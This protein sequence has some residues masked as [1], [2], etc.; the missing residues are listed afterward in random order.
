MLVGSVLKEYGYTNIPLS[1]FTISLIEKSFKALAF[2]L[3]PLI[4]TQ[5]EIDFAK[6]IFL[7][8]LEEELAKKEM[9]AKLNL[10]ILYI[11]STYETY[12]L[13]GIEFPTCYFL[14][15]P[16]I[17]SRIIRACYHLRR[18]IRNFELKVIPTQEDINYLIKSQKC[19]DL[20]LFPLS[21]KEDLA[22]YILRRN[23]YHIEK[24]KIT[25]A[26]LLAECN[27]NSLLKEKLAIIEKL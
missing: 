22:D 18:I 9:Y 8:Y 12:F 25:F 26:T 24:D 20:F 5:E 6:K 23:G 11:P 2:A 13:E 10:E 15:E 14:A 19:V 1:T 7:R 3:I 21:F 4:K 17:F 27:D 16:D